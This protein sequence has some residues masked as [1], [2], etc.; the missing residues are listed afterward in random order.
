MQ[1]KET[2]R[3]FRHR[4]EQQ[5]RDRRRRILQGLIMIACLVIVALGVLLA[6]RDCVGL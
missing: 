4:R 3:V 1:L 5:Q 2:R 6:L